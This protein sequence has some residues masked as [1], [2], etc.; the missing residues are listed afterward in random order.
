MTGV[1]DAQKAWHDQTGGAGAI[2][3]SFGSADKSAIRTVSFDVAVTAEAAS[4]GQ[5]GGGIKVLGIG[6]DGKLSDSVANSTVSRIQYVVP[7][8]PPV[9]QIGQSWGGTLPPAKGVV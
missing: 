6:V 2:N 5:A 1:R 8:I 9:I 3:P 7:V 4:Q